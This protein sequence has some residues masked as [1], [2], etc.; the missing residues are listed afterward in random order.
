MAIENLYDEVMMDHIKNARNYREIP[1]AHRKTTAVN[2]LC[3][4]EITVYLRFQYGRIDD[5]AF[6]CSSCGISMASA[7]IMTEAVKGK[8]CAEARNLSQA[9]RALIDDTTSTQALLLSPE[10]TAALA[11]LKAFPARKTCAALAWHALTS[12]LDGRREAISVG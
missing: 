5:V 10:F 4:D 3:G 7:S 12:A 9:V 11:A 2:R 6:L 1:E 8:T